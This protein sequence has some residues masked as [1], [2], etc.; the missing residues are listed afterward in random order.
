MWRNTR[1][2]GLRFN[3]T[4]TISCHRTASNIPAQV[5]LSRAGFTL[6]TTNRLHVVVTGP[7]NPERN[8]PPAR[9]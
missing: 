5:P 4:R 2:S 6:P 7:A 9:R 3:G 8:Q 1:P